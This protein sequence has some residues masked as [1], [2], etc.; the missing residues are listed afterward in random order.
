MVLFIKVWKFGE[1]LSAHCCFDSG[2]VFIAPVVSEGFLPISWML[3]IVD[4]VIW[5]GNNA[6]AAL[7]HGS[8]SDQST[9]CAFWYPPESVS[10]F[11][12]EKLTLWC[13]FVQFVPTFGGQ[14][15]VFGT[16]FLRE[17]E[18]DRKEKFVRHTGK[19]HFRAH[20]CAV[21]AVDEP[22][23]KRWKW[24]NPLGSAGV[25]FASAGHGEVSELRAVWSDVDS[26][27]CDIFVET[28]SS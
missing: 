23:P 24:L 11:L 5:D 16:R 10:K 26:V 8:S 28:G 17:S 25:E 18:E 2:S 20:V 1:E 6:G 15:G 19:D 22:S 27:G 9:V 21:P 4:F 3:I 13:S 12:R 7:S 14:G